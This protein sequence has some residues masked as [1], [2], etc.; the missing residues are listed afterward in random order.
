MDKKSMHTDE[1][2]HRPVPILGVR[3]LLAWIPELNARLVSFMLLAGAQGWQERLICWAR[4][5][6]SLDTWVSMARPLGDVGSRKRLRKSGVRTLE[7]L[8]SEVV[9][10]ELAN[11]NVGSD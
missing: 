11:V 8:C 9:V 5:R 4:L 2:S 6:R 1:Q 10:S 7:G 3:L